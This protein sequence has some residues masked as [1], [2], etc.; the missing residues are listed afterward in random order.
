MMNEKEL[1]IQMPYTTALELIQKA[2][3]IATVERMANSKSYY[4][5]EEIYTVLGIKVKEENANATV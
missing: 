3:R 1:V 5:P 2:E 4:T